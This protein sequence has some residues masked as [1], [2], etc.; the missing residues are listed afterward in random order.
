MKSILFVCTG[1]ICRSPTA[2]AILRH[3]VKE[4]GLDITVDSA[5]THAYH[6]G[7][8]PDDR[9]I[10]TA[11]SQGIEMSDLRARK[12]QKSDFDKF[13]CLIAMDNGHL[14]AMKQLAKQHHQNKLHL[15]LDFT[16][17]HKG[18]DVP[19]PYYGTQKDFNHVYSIVFKGCKNI[20]NSIT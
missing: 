7:E 15:F 17:E 3:L 13:D 6:V 5:G 18:K 9:T 16:T 12:L 8:Q 19:D 20:L 4:E 2:D 1:N 10:K 14:Q 11:Q